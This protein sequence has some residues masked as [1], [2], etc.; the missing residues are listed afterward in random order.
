MRNWLVWPGIAF[1]CGMTFAACGARTGLPVPEV[2]TC[3][4]VDATAEIADLDVLMMIDKSG[5]MLDATASGSTK[6]DAARNAIVS[7]LSLPDSEGIGVGLSFFP[8]IDGSIPEVCANDNTCG[9]AGA[10]KKY[11]IC[12]PNGINDQQLCDT[13]Q[14]C[15]DSGYPDDTCEP[16]GFCEGDPSVACFLAQITCDGDLGSCLPL[17]GCQNRYVC[18]ADQYADPLANVQTLPE[19]TNVLVGQIDSQTPTGGTT[20]KPALQAAIDQALTWSESHPGHKPIV[21]LA[22]DGEPTLCDPAAE[23]PVWDPAAITHLVEIA[24]EGANAGVQTFVLGVFEPEK[25]AQATADLNQI[26]VAGGTKKAF[27]VSTSADVTAELLAALNEVRISSKSCE[28]ALPTL[29]EGPL[30]PKKLEV[31]ITPPGG[32]PVDV[33]RR[34]SEGGCHPVDGG[35]YYDKPLN[36]DVPPT[37]VIL[38]PASCALFGGTLNRTVHLTVSC[39]N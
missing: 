28:F 27:I 24:T 10:C 35:F 12:I 15:A 6:W 9:E 13:A 33:P 29:E 14:D 30:D 16:L 23:D 26:A 19:G 20:T 8:I 1:F 2:E 39:G 25:E 4:T 11:S 31:E 34:D 38:C 32:D 37:R 36:E 22:T 18:D 5:S 3:V 21:V 17:G 7:F